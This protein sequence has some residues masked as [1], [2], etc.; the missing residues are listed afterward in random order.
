[1]AGKIGVKLKLSK[2][3]LIDILCITFQSPLHVALQTRF[4][5]LLTAGYKSIVKY[6]C[7]KHLDFKE[8]N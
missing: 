1:M 7:Y 6:L 2:R 5:M 3:R 8:N 4:I